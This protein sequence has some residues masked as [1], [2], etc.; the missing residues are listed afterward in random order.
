MDEKRK[1]KIMRAIS[2]FIKTEVSK[3]GSKGVV[4]GMSGGID[5]SVAACL[6]V[7]S[8]RPYPSR[9]ICNTGE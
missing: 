8:I 4:I 1:N 9:F 3:R 5:S 7:K 2:Q 6:A